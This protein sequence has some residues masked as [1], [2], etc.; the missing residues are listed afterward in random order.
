M[1]C[2]EGDQVMVRLVDLGIGRH[3]G[4]GGKCPAR[5]A[6]S[7]VPDFSDDALVPPVNR[8]REVLNSDLLPGLHLH[9][10]GLATHCLQRETTTG[11]SLGK[12]FSGK[13]YLLKVGPFL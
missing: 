12:L 1:L 13:E 11:V 5:P 6:L 9:V 4:R 3:G 8:G 10:T 7:L 2:G